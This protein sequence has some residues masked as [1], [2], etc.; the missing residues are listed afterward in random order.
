MRSAGRDLWTE[1]LGVKVLL[2]WT[3][4][5]MVLAAKI[6]LVAIPLLWIWSF[7][8]DAIVKPHDMNLPG[9]LAVAS[10]FYLWPWWLIL[11]FVGRLLR[12]SAEWLSD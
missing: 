10:V 3:G 9:L 1:G 7:A 6:W 5:L 11:Y 4:W 12:Q 2:A 8:Y